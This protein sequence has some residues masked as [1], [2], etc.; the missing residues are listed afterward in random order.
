[1]HE[2]QT[3]RKAI[4]SVA[5]GAAALGGPWVLGGF[6]TDESSILPNE[7]PDL[8]VEKEREPKIT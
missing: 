4:W 7:Q 2:M 6:R 3:F 1:M 5:L 8:R